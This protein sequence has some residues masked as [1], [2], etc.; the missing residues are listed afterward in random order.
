MPWIETCPMNERMKFIADHLKDEW[1]VVMLY[2][3]Y[4]INR[5][6]AYKW[7]AHYQ[8]A[9]IIRWLFRE[10]LEFLEDIREDHMK[11][12]DPVLY[13]KHLKY[14]RFLFSYTS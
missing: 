10:P 13:E 3:Y 9:G 1:S 2:R 7:L 5:K 11:R 8:Q 6:T 4:G 14:V 12:C